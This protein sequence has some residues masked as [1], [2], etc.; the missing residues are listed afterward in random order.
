MWTVR[1]MIFPLDFW[2]YPGG[3]CFYITSWIGS[4]SKKYWESLN[5]L[6]EGFPQTDSYERLIEV[7]SLSRVRRWLGVVQ[8][9]IEN[10]LSSELQLREQGECWVNVWTHNKC[11]TAGIGGERSFCPGCSRFYKSV[12]PWL[13]W[14]VL[15]GSLLMHVIEN[16]SYAAYFLGLTYSPNLMV[17]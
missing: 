6:R 12:S 17:R 13:L 8:L 10:I 14:Y 15:M 5:F 11:N 9:A 16:L 1:S 2:N 7:W 3:T 4:A